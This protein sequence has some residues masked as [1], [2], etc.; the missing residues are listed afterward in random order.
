MRVPLLLLLAF[1]LALPAASAAS[2][3]VQVMGGFFDPP[4][5]ELSPGDKVTWTNADSMPHTVTSAWD[6]GASFDA[7]LRAGESFTFAFPEEGAWTIHC[8]PHSG[9]EMKVTVNAVDAGAGIAQ[10]LA[11]TP[12]P[13][14]GLVA[15]ALVGA[16]LLSRRAR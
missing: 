13:T 5:V 10:P 4:S 14:V 7:V 12:G 9:M 8:R 1:I 11:R 16:L 2:S 3:S 15:I 6:A